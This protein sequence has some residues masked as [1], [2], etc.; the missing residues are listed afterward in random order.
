ATGAPGPL[1]RPDESSI[2]PQAP[3]KEE[4]PHGRS[5]GAPISNAHR[6]WGSSPRPHAAT[7]GADSSKGSTDR[8]H[9]TYGSMASKSTSICRSVFD[10]ACD[11]TRSL[12]RGSPNTPDRK[13]TRLNSS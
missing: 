12:T 7:A 8:I 9:S 6:G 2:Y 13:S 10:F 3:Q 5:Q 1:E 4:A 11:Q